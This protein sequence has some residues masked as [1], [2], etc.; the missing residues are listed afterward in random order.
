MIAWAVGHFLPGGPFVGL[1]RFFSPTSPRSPS[2]PECGLA[3]RRTPA[4]CCQ[5]GPRLGG[6][7]DT[8]ARNPSRMPPNT[9][10][11]AA[12]WREE[13]PSPPPPHQRCHPIARGF[14]REGPRDERGEGQTPNRPRFVA[15]L[16][17]GVGPGLRL[18]RTLSS[19]KVITPPST[20]GW[21]PQGA[22]RLPEGRPK[23]SL[24]LVERDRLVP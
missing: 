16:L 22:F 13:R 23:S 17:S 1:S 11:S 8:R 9:S 14:W 15:A 18:R 10:K 21:Q 6:M 5:N 2:S 20:C 24:G 19:A 3:R 7:F 12:I 4:R